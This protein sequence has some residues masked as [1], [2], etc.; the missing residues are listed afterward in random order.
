MTTTDVFHFGAF[1]GLFQDR[2]NLVFG[3]SDSLLQSLLTFI[4]P[5]TSSYYLCSF[6][7]ELTVQMIPTKLLSLVIF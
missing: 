1:I 5:E 7:G 4:L 6:L 2:N 3:K